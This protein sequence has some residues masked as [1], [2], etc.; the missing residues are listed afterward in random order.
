MDDFLE[1]KPKKHSDAA[2]ATAAR[3]SWGAER[4]GSQALMIRIP[5]AP[6][7]LTWVTN[8]RER[9]WPAGLLHSSR[10]RARV[11]NCSNSR[12][13]VSVAAEIQSVK[14]KFSN[15][16][17]VFISTCY[18]VGNAGEREPTCAAIREHLTKIS[19]M[20]D[21]K[22]HFLIGDFNLNKVTWPGAGVT[23]PARASRKFLMCSWIWVL[24]S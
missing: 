5:L 20:R 6:R 7:P 18:R 21:C 10:R 22:K 2:L 24:T 15:G 17:S 19:K 12:V 8:T 9:V 16:K 3:F 1:K 11:L 23:P 14:I 13:G 4:A